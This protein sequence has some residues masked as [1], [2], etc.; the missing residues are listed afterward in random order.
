MRRFKQKYKISFV[1][2][3]AFKIE[4]DFLEAEIAES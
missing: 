4:V 3:S 2:Q 1:F